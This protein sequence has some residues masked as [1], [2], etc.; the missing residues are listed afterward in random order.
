MKKNEK[1]SS[2]LALTAMVKILMTPSTALLRLVF[3]ATN[4]TF[5][6]KS[7]VWPEKYLQFQSQN[8]EFQNG[9]KPVP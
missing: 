2:K 1:N 8:K 7:L 4:S 5:P 9:T 3:P 6:S